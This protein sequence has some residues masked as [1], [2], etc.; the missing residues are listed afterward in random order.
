MKGNLFRRA[1]V[2]ATGVT[3]QVLYCELAGRQVR[4]L[5]VERQ[6]GLHASNAR[7]IFTYFGLE[8]LQL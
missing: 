4:Y 5:G 2:D 7:L 1:K 3:T 6:V 8:K